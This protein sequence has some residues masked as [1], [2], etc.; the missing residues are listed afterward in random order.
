ML[1]AAQRVTGFSNTLIPHRILGPGNTVDLV[2]TPRALPNPKTVRSDVDDNVTLVIEW[3][4]GQQAV[5]RALWGTSFFRNDTAI[6][7]RYGALFISSAGDVIVHSP[8]REIQGAE[9][10]IWNG[11]SH[12]YRVPITPLADS[13]NEGHIEHFIDCFEEIREPI[14]GWQ[15]QLHVHEILFKAYVAAR[16]H[17]S[18]E[19]D[20]TFKPW[21]PVDNTFQDTRSR[22]T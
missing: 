6:Y 10:L 19:L 9:P 16:T 22:P 3:P 5:L 12:C 8:A 7:G 14:C 11:Y 20:T 2:P 15:Q 13:R 4:G 17:T 1:G 18:Q 21:H